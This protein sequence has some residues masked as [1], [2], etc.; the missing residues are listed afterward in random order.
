[1]Q[2]PDYARNS[3]CTRGSGVVLN[4]FKKSEYDQDI[5]H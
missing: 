2:L 3:V 1:M 4:L 5:P